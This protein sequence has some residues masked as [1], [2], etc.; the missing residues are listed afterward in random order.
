M[1]P[2]MMIFYVSNVAASA[3]FFAAVLGQI[4]AE[5]TPGFAMFVLT[6]GL[7]VGLWRA[8]AVWPAA[9]IA[10]VGAELVIHMPGAAEVLAMHESLQASGI[11]AVAAPQERE[12][13][14]SF[15]V[16][17]PDGQRVRYLHAAG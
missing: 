15:V 7:K 17:S 13:G 6:N 10:G 11:E 9:P 14:T 4:P 8:D 3:E 5:Q 12:F 1:T 16:A 2:D